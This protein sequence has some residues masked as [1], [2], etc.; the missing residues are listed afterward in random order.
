MLLSD[1]VGASWR[2]LGSESVFDLTVGAGDSIWGRWFEWHIWEPSPK[3]GVCV[4]RDGGRSFAR[5]EFEDEELFPYGFV[6]ME[7]ADPLLL[8]DGGLFRIIT[9]PDEPEASI[10]T[11]GSPIPDEPIWAGIICH[12]KLYV[13]TDLLSPDRYR[14]RVWVSHDSGESWRQQLELADSEVPSE[15]FYD[16]AC[17][18]T[19]D[20]WCATVWG[21]IFHYDAGQGVWNRIID[22]GETDYSE[23]IVSMAGHEGDLIVKISHALKPAIRVSTLGQVEVLGSLDLHIL[24]VDPADRLWG[25]GIDGL[26]RWDDESQEWERMWRAR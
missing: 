26:F 21:V 19:G 20:L 7:G 9:S 12:D 10:E 1:D 17:S 18:G 3:F 22:L 2:I 4:S 14:S 24:K 8:A 13:G 23:F 15:K 5:L 6:E 11:F 16:F 25:A